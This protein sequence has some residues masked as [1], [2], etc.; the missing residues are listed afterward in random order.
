MALGVVTP[1]AAASV[2]DPVTVSSMRNLVTAME[3]YAMFDGGDAY[4]G[5]TAEVLADWGWAPG[6]STHVDVWVENGGASWRAAGQDTRPGAREY[7]YTSSV[8]VNG[9]NPGTVSLSVPQ[10][11]APASTAGVTIHDVGSGIDIDALALALVTA[12]VTIPEVCEV[13]LVAPGTHAAGSS[14]PDSYL[15]CD[16]AALATAATMRSVLSAIAKAGGAGALATIALFV[17][18]DQSAPATVPPWVS[19][20]EGKPTPPVTTSPTLPR[21]IWTWGKTAQRVATLNDLDP[22]DAEVVTQQCL[23]LVTAALV[24]TDPFKDC[25]QTPIFAS[26]QLD[27]PEATRHDLE[28]LLTT[29]TWVALNYRP[30]ASNPSYEGWYTNDPICQAKAPGQNCDE[31][32]FYATQ[33]GGHL[34]VPRPSLKAIDGP[35]NQT[36]GSLY[37]SFRAGCHLADGDQFL[38]VPIPATAAHLPTL[39]I[40]NGH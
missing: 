28:A 35:Q 37:N 2:Y 26:G 29:P 39:Q 32:P 22:E 6:S 23:R 3:S 25:T 24:S 15:A 21:T 30:K 10:P 40:C 20:P 14:V 36:Q 8:P 4:G 12:G 19:T 38:A 33:Q 11:V 5:V 16:G 7:T 9:A 17:V 1:A 34:A 13:T 31:Y 27:V 18:G